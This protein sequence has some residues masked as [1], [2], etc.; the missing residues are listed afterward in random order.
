MENRNDERAI[1]LSDL[2]FSVLYRWKLIL[3]CA[4]AF[5]LLLGGFKAGTSLPITA[6][7]AAATEA[8]NTQRSYLTQRLETIQNNIEGQQAYID[9]SLLMQ[10]DPYNY[11]Q[12]TMHLYVGAQEQTPEFVQSLISAYQAMATGQESLQALGQALELDAAYVAGAFTIPQIQS[13]NVFSL[14]LNC[15]TLE[16]AQIAQGVLENHMDLTAAKLTGAMGEHQLQLLES[17]ISP[18]S[19][20]DLAALQSAHIQQLKALQTE[21]KDTKTQLSALAA[22]QSVSKKDALKDAVVFAVLG[23]AFGFAASAGLS[24]LAH[25]VSNKV[26]SCRALVNATGIRLIGALR[27]GKTSKL[28]A[29]EGRDTAPAEARTTMLATHIRNLSSGS[30]LL[31]GATDPEIRQ[32][33]ADAIRAA[34][35]NATVYNE[36]DILHSADALAALAE[37]DCVVLAEQCGSSRYSD[38]SRRMD[39]IADHDK[40]LLGCVLYGG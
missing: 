1:Y 39:M 13:T 3:V 18:S 31:T 22:P 34:I 9:N 21:Q 20:K 40:H 14:Y 35:P 26:Y 19:S 8:Y 38:V 12:L 36:S 2:I 7:D 29:L 24:C 23:A 28:Q 25:I 27:S 6:A 37:C 10:L 16:Q 11:Y 17:S 33:L 30:I 5:A 15:A 4:L 32:T